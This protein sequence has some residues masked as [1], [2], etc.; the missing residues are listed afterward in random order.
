MANQGGIGTRRVHD[1]TA[2]Q[3]EERQVP[4]AQI[5]QSNYGVSF[6]EIEAFLVRFLREHPRSRRGAVMKAFEREFGH[7]FTG[8]DKLPRNARD[9]TPRWQHRIDSKREKL[10]ETGIMENGSEQGVWSL[11]E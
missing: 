2:L 11:T 6:P 1:T 7:R 10:A 4:S 9:K 8:H 3:R 5:R